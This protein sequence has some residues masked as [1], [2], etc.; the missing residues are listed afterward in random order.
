MKKLVLNP[1]MYKLLSDLIESGIARGWARAFKYVEDPSEEEIVKAIVDAIMLEFD[2]SFRFQK[3]LKDYAR[4]KRMVVSGV[5]LGIMHAFKHTDEP[6]DSSVENH[7]H[8][9]V[10]NTLCEKVRM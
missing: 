10:M 6:L 5:K 2:E 4:L 8:N 9:D 7:C 1:D 3:D